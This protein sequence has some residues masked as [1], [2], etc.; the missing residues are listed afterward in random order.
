MLCRIAKGKE[1]WLRVL[2][3]VHEL[4][5]LQRAVAAETHRER[6][7]RHSV[8]CGIEKDQ[9]D[10]QGTDGVTDEPQQNQG[11]AEGVPCITEANVTRGRASIG[12]HKPTRNHRDNSP[13]VEV[14]DKRTRRERAMGTRLRRHLY[15][16]TGDP[17]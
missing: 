14:A 10:T 6:E 2:L 4:L 16:L 11:G 5:A 8:R 7:P 17:Q 12:R 1:A 9:K 3:T 15:A 13:D